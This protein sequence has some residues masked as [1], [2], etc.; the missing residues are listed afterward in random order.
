MNILFLLH[1]YPKIGGIEVVSETLSRYL[2]KKHNIFYLARISVNN[3][4]ANEDNCYLFPSRNKGECINFYNNL[5]SELKI[6]VVINQGPFI[7]YTK[8]LSN[9]K[10]DTSVRIFSVLHFSPGFEFEYIKYVW[11]TEKPGFRRIF[12]RIKTKLGLNTLQY[13]PEKTRSKYR[14]L[15][16]ISDKVILL[17]PQYISTF[18][19]AYKLKEDNK[20]ISI[21]NPTR[22]N[23]LDSDILNK[24]EKVIVY[25]GRLELEQKRVDRLLD[26]WSRVSNKGGWRLKIIGDGPH[27]EE[28]ES[29]VKRNNIEQVEFIGAVSDVT[30][31]YTEASVVAITSTYEGFTLCLIEGIQFGAIPMA[32]NVCLGNNEF[33]DN[34]S[35]NLNV[36][37][38]DVDLYAKQ[39]SEIMN[40]NEY[41]NT[42]AQK[43]IEEGKRFD[44]N[45]VGAI[46]DRLISDNKI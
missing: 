46:W 4:G 36:T 20:L 12:K 5:V 21:H 1:S 27:R 30:P 16:E 15:Y 14:K 28:I 11:M 7:P 44:I 13:N 23:C 2:S 34:I 33:I 39:L 29:I 42:L 25:V 41:R 35:N 22:Y 19:E 26:I 38:F 17:S 43:S 31:Y 32:F 24:K 3:Y 9:P 6:D 10:R 37:P 18:K 8:I 40:N 45:Y